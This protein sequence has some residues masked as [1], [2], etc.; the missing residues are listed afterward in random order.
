MQKAILDAYGILAEHGERST[1]FNGEPVIKV[2]V[3]PI[4]AGLCKPSPAAWRGPSRR[5]L[6]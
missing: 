4:N 6:S 2:S 3:K 1:G 5:A